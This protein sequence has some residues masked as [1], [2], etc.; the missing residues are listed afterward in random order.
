MRPTRPWRISLVCIAHAAWALACASSQVGGTDADAM[1]YRLADSGSHWDIVGQDRVLDDL[2]PRYP[3]FFAVVLDPGRSDEPPTRRIRLHL[4]HAPVD[5]RNYDALNAVAMAYF[6]LNYRGETSRGNADMGF[7]S[8]GFRTAKLA[9]IPW[10]AYGEIQDPNLRDAI[11]DFF[12]DAGQGNK[13]GAQATA[14]RLSRIVASLAPK[15]PDPVRRARIEALATA[16]AR[17]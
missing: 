5:R 17:E 2:Q 14:G 3:D 12:Q 6:E 13:L 1:R 16:L 8:A 10:R 11:L 4:E 15:E 9:A 7:V